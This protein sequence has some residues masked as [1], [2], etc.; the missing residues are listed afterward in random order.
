MGDPEYGDVPPASGGYL[1]VFTGA[2]AKSVLDLVPGR[3]ELLVGHAGYDTRTV[4]LGVRAAPGPIP[5]TPESA[6]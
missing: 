1:R 2:Q 5:Q 6:G 4:E 3:Y